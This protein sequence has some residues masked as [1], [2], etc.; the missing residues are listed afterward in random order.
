MASFVLAL[1]ELE[2][3]GLN[4][5][6]ALVFAAAPLTSALQEEVKQRICPNLYEY[7][8]LQ[9]TGILT[10]LGPEEKNRKPDS[11]GQVMFGAEVRLVDA[12]GKDVRQG[13]VGEILGRAPTATT[14]YYKDEERTRQAFADGW[15]HTGDLGRFDQEGFLYLSGRVKDMIISGGQNVFSVEVEDVL[16]SHPDVADCAVIGLPDDTWGEMVTAVVIRAPG[17]PVTDEQLIA[18]CRERMA[19][20]KAPKRIIWTEEPLPRTPTGKVTKFVL[21]EKYTES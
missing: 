5:L 12:E 18:F 11:V 14:G 8:G 13:E 17:S 15:F 6:R 9:E 20:F 1:P 10:S 21:V 16:M 4:S 19:G 2:K 7:Y 3:H